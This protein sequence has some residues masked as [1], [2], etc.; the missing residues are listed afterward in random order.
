MKYSKVAATA[1]VI[2]IC[3]PLASCRTEGSPVHD[4]GIRQIDDNGLR[5]PFSTVHSRR[6]NAANDGT[7][8]EP[9]TALAATQLE[10]HGIDPH[11]VKDAAGTNGQTLRGCS[12]D[13]VGDIRTE[14]WMLSQIVGN[15]T[16]L[17]ND[18]RMKSTTRDIWLDDQTADGRTVGLH[19]I[20]PN[21]QC[22]T[23]VQ[24]GKAAVT[25]LVMHIG[26]AEQPLSA[27]CDR[28]IAFTRATIGRMPE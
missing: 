8:Y 13:Y 23:Y 20:A 6:W 12:W 14:H 25:T 16:G 26:R 5:L 22:D 2:A 21:I 27:L 15:S 3:S 28:A 9:C 24:S 10:A 17:A 19:A 7:T 1:L 18:K 4:H 11:S